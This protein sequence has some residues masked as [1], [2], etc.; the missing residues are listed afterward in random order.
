M[1][2]PIISAFVLLCMKQHEFES[3][4]VK[5]AENVKNFIHGSKEIFVFP[6]IDIGYIIT[7]AKQPGSGE[8]KTLMLITDFVAPEE[9][10]EQV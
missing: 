4:K 8:K 9:A 7:P 1:L 10:R 3:R 6:Y 5:M 2:C